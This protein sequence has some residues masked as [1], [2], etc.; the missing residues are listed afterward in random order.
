LWSAIGRI[1]DLFN[2]AECA[3]YLAAA[4]YDAG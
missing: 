4:S 1:V 3:N 2:P